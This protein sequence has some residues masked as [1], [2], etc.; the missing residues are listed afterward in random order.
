VCERHVRGEED[1]IQQR[2]AVWGVVGGLV[3]EGG[4]PCEQ[5]AVGLCSQLELST[6]DKCLSHR[7]S[8]HLDA[9][10][11]VICWDSNLVAVDIRAKIISPLKSM[12]SAQ[13][14]LAVEPR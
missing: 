9:Y 10:R 12:L 4:Q 1:V 3:K 11:T 7:L 5:L 6:N 13:I 8:V 2:T 14:S